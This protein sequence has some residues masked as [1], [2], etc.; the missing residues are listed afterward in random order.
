MHYVC[1][2]SLVVITWS[3]Y[4]KKQNEP[5]IRKG[6]PKYAA[7]VN[8]RTQVFRRKN[9]YPCLKSFF[10]LFAE[11][12]AE[13]ELQAINTDFTFELFICAAILLENR[14]SLLKCQDEVQL[15][16][17][18]SRFVCL[19]QERP[20]I[21][22][23]F[24]LTYGFLCSLHGTLD[25]NSTLE[26]AERHL[27]NYCKRCTRDFMKGQCRVLESGEEDFLYQLR[28]LLVLK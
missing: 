28:S 15:I 7:Q 2:R 13:S 26:K 12:S 23:C 3:S 10:L 27:Y 19:P 9:S 1:L 4:L 5:V 18:T 11:D 22:L 20:L 16:Q 24:G 21:F 14:E 25:L 6:W 17:F 8:P